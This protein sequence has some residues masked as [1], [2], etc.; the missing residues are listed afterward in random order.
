VSRRPLPA[1][2]RRWM[3]IALVVLIL[4]ALVVAFLR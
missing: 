2:T 1:L 4:I 3:T